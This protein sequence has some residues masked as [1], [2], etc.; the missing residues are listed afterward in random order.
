MT[1]IRFVA[2]SVSLLAAAAAT[3][4]HLAWAGVHVEGDGHAIGQERAVERRER[5]DFEHEQPGWNDRTEAHDEQDDHP[6]ESHDASELV[7]LSELGSKMAG[8]RI[9]TVDRR[10]L[11]GTIELPGEIG[12]N[13]DRLAHMT[14]RYGGVVKEVIKGL[15]DHVETGEVLAVIESNQSLTT[16]RVLAPLSGRVVEKHVTPGEYVSEETS[17]YVIADLATVWANLDVYPAHLQHVTVGSE[18]TVRGVGADQNTTAV[19]SYVAPV[20]DR[21]KRAVVARAILANT[22]G[23]WRPGMF[24]RAEL[25]TASD[26][27]VTAVAEEAVQMLDG[28]TC[29]FVPVGT[30]QF[31]PVEVDVGASG[32]GYVEI[33]SG[34]GSGDRYVAAGGFELKAEMITSSLGDHAGHGH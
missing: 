30:N 5:G 27:A 32:R 22:E 7:D 17:I 4:C 16:Y 21:G 6:E 11:S 24:V 18:L 23:A 26:E 15:G 33:L 31:K 3:L 34:L 25:A 20:F 10:S 29:V 14:P 1:S 19:V 13:E 9:A 12:F 2:V 8:I 28:R